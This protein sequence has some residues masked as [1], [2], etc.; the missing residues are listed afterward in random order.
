[1]AISKGNASTGPST[2]VLLLF[3]FVLFRNKIYAGRVLEGNS[4]SSKQQAPFN[5][6][7]FPLK[8]AR[9]HSDTLTGRRQESMLRLTSMASGL[10]HWVWGSTTKSSEHSWPDL[11]YLSTSYSIWPT[12]RATWKQI[13]WPQTIPLS[14]AWALI[15]E[16]ATWCTLRVY[17]TMYENIFPLHLWNV[18]LKQSPDLRKRLKTLYY[19]CNCNSTEQ[20]ISRL[21]ECF[22]DGS[23]SKSFNFYQVGLP[24]EPHLCWLEKIHFKYGEE[25]LLLS[26]KALSV[27]TSLKGYSTFFGNRLILPL[28]RS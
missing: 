3:I 10:V 26:V 24:W 6:G 4:K 13:K 8:H 18:L 12:K 11:P 22:F 5:F 21:I 9:M 15:E 17:L 23:F 27:N 1:M 19:S 14:L 28:P 2:I 20:I 25:F 16:W 7:L